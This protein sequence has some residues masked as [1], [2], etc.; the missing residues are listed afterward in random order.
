MTRSTR[1][2]ILATAWFGTSEARAATLSVNVTDPS[3]S[4]FRAQGSPDTASTAGGNNGTTIGEQRLIAFQFAADVWGSLLESPVTV[5]VDASMSNLECSSNSAVLGSAA[6]T[7]FYSQPSTGKWYPAALADTLNGSD[8]DPGFPDIEATFNARVDQS[9]CLGSS[10]WYYGLDGAPP[11]NRVDFLSVVLHELG[12]GLGV[13]AMID[14]DTGE[15]LG[16]DDEPDA[17]GALV[18]DNEANQA[19]PE[20]NAA[21][22]AQSISRVRQIA[23][24]GPSVTA[25]APEFL[26]A[27]SPQVVVTPNVPAFSAAISETNFGPTVLNHSAE[28]P[29]IE[30]ANSCNVPKDLDGAVVLLR[31]RGCLGVDEAANAG[32]LAVLIDTDDALVP[33]GDLNLSGGARTTIPTL[34]LATGD[35]DALSD[36]LSAQTLSVAITASSR[37]VGADDQG[38]VLL[39]ATSPI[40]HG[41]SI[42]HWDSLTR[43]SAAL[44][45]G[46]RD[47]LMEPAGESVGS[48]VDL[49]VHMLQDLGWGAALCGDGDVDTGEQCDTGTD[50]S[51]T[52]PDACRTNCR[53]ASCGDGVTDSGEDCDDG[54]DNGTG[55]A[56]C[57]PDCTAP[58]C[59]NGTLEP[60]E[61]CDD[62][63][64]NSDTE[65]DSCRTTCVRPYCGDG[66]EDA[67]ELCDDGN[68]NGSA[69]S[70]CLAD[71]QRVTCGDGIVA[72]TEQCD[73]GDENSNLL[74]NSCRR[75]CQLPHC[76]DGVIDATEECDDA[77]GNGTGADQC[78]PD[79]A[80]PRC[81]DGIVDRGEECDDGRSNSDESPNACRSTC[82]LAG[83][84]DGILGPGEQCD[85]G[86]TRDDDDCSS[87]CR[88]NLASGADGGP[89]VRPSPSTPR[90][91]G[92]D[93]GSPEP[94]V[95]PSP[96]EDTSSDG[97]VNHADG[98]AGTT[99]H[100]VFD[101]ATDE[102]SMPSSADLKQEKP[103]CSCRVVGARPAG[104]PTQGGLA[105]L[106]AGIGCVWL[107][108]RRRTRSHLGC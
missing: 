22:R 48:G 74:P 68:L 25:A 35:A 83:C 37:L 66:V 88:L 11:N 54:D 3:G 2:A 92:E 38:R 69:N 103:D 86:N 26:A 14:L 56:Q 102:P 40:E 47:L 1:W 96:R 97:P 16:G 99:P 31:F 50:N 67:N 15:F 30:V 70:S 33:P 13:V 100:P 76:G 45:D 46:E 89:P 85:D 9:N 65:A 71:C 12:H 93:D 53:L 29:L 59:G 17:F 87:V 79:C 98:D 34:H 28:G 23:W 78:R 82:R 94:S 39:N 24:N 72:G 43:R 58:R 55:A 84:G 52:E 27:G 108:R 36:A 20:M 19:W 64:G 91:L 41:S 106:I 105:G 7:F 63:G 32:A 49:T 60:G 5:Q 51:N 57:Q 44:D 6:P 80:A 81:G 77:A 73:D 8:L 42:S 4:G 95:E 21:Q 90:D 10:R 62:G 101:A 61:E 107:R 104:I 18:F 75:D